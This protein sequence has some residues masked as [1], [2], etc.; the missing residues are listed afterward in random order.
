[1]KVRVV[2]AGVG[3]IS[4]SDVVLAQASEAIIVGFH[5]SALSDA[6]TAAEREGVE[7]RTYRIIY[8]ALDDV[9]SA[10]LGLLEP[11]KKEVKLGKA[12]VRQVFRIPRVGQIL[13]CY[14]TE[15]K[16]RRDAQVKVWR[17]C[18]IFAGRITTLKRFKDDVREVETGYECGVGIENAP[19]LQVGDILEAFITEEKP[20]TA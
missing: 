7:I 4:L 11:E 5:V 1:V 8:D 13:G 9:R 12:E 6:A 14:I 3:S 20:R 18:E 19:E 16:L 17:D 15:G 10:M 2:H